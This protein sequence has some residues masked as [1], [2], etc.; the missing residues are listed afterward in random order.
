VEWVER[1][2]Q[3]EEIVHETEPG[4]SWLRRTWLE[5]VGLLPIDWML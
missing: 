1:T 2:A 4:T 5:F 3:G